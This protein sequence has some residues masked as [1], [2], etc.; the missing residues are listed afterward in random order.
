MGGAN[1]GSNAATNAATNSASNA[2][3]A[4][5]ISANSGAAGGV[6]AS[7]QNVFPDGVRLK[8]YLPQDK[9]LGTGSQDLL[10]S[11]P[12]NDPSLTMDWVR[13]NF[14]AAKL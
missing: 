12:Q 5:A 9:V 4:N 11:N 3:N 7:A 1:V 8:L 10:V 6:T 13:L 14:T 2:I